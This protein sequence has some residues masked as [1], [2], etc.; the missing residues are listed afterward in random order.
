MTPPEEYLQKTSLRPMLA[1]LLERTCKDKPDN[2]VPFMLE[3]LQATYPDAAKAANPA[4]APGSFGTWA[5]RTDVQPT[6][7]G[8]QAYLT[9][10]K[11][12]STLE[13]VLEQALRQQPANV[14]AFVIDALCSGEELLAAP[15]GSAAPGTAA[16]STAAADVYAD[17][18]TRQ[19]AVVHPEAPALFEAVG[20]GDVERVEQI[21]SSGVPV[22]SLNDDAATAL[23]IAAEGEPSIVALLLSN[24]S[25]VDHQ[26]KNGST[27]LIAAIKY[28]DPEIVEMLLAAGASKELTDVIGR[29]GI[30]YATEAGDE[31]VLEKLGIASEAAAFPEPPVPKAGGRRGSVSSE[32]IDPKAHIDTST[33]KVVPKEDS[34]KDRIKRTVCGNLLFKPLDREQ[35]E[36][37]VLSMEEIKVQRGEAIIRQGDE[38]HH[39]YVVDSGTFECFVKKPDDGLETPGKKVLDY[40]E[41]TT[42]GEL[43]LMYNCPRAASVIATSE[44]VLWAMDRETFRT[45]ILQMMSAKRMRFEALLETVPLLRSMDAYERTAV[46]DAFEERSYAAGEVILTEAEQGDTFYLLVSGSAVATKAGPEGTKQLLE[47]KGGDYFGE[48]ALLDNRPRAASVE[49]VTD[50]VCVHLARPIFERLLGPVVHILKR[51]AENYKSYADGEIIG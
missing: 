16:G 21:L 27:A 25:K 36:A 44:A 50:C 1:S 23:H 39:F 24:G 11:A 34:V 17:V 37:V 22:D 40:G 7:E 38:G 46:A 45:V 8:L 41:G 5:R 9:Q 51:N 15:T 31:R 48:L 4:N 13:T 33:I 12:R 49:C 29:S 28:E 20:E 10:V 18:A 19:E 6:Q 14:V 47:Y 30:D 26:D 42:F 35:L 43:A 2:L 32:S 3:Y